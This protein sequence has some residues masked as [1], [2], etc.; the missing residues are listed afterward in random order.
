MVFINLKGIILFPHDSDE[1]YDL[2]LDSNSKQIGD[3]QNPEFFI[4]LTLNDIEKIIFTRRI[5]KTY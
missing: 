2:Q 5:Y 4:N 1:S 3:F